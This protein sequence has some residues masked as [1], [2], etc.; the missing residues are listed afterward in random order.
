MSAAT[1]AH[2]GHGR[3]AHRRVA[4]SRSRPSA[5][6]V[7][8]STAWTPEERF[9]VKS[10]KPCTCRSPVARQAAVDVAM[11]AV[12]S[13]DTLWASA[14]IKPTCPPKASSFRCRL[15]QRETIAAWWLGRNA[16]RGCLDDLGDLYEAGASAGPCRRAATIKPS[17]ASRAAW[18]HHA[19]RRGAGRV[20]QRHR[21]LE[22]DDQPVGERWSSSSRTAWQRRDCG[23]RADLGRCLRTTRSAASRSGSPAKRCRVGQRSAT[24]SRGSVAPIRAPRTRLRGRRRALAEVEALI[25]RRPAPTRAATSSAVDGAGHPQGPAHRIDAMNGYIRAQGRRGRR[26]CAE[27][28]QLAENR[29]RAWSAASSR[30]RLRIWKVWGSDKPGKGW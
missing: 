7:S 6:A 12:K 21:Q 23:D 14:L 28:C 17:S 1:L 22:G 13:Y 4:W 30:H 5:R 15:P 29:G 24:P 11:V 26:A 27:P 19:A 16:R 3:D 20:V 10:A 18:A 25:V 9:T 8:S 2:L